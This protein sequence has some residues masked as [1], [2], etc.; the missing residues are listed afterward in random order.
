MKSEAKPVFYRPRSVPYAIKEAI[1][2]EIERLEKDGIIEK[3]EHS[4]WAAPIVPVPK[5]DGQI[6]ICGDNKVTVNAN[7]EVDQHPLPNLR[8]YSH[9][10]Q[11]ARNSVSWISNMLINR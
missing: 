5:G 3:V 4:E 2:K 1:E 6:R 11:E 8:T 9:H 7:L 10:C